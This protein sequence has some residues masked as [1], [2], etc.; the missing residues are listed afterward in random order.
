M[1]KVQKYWLQIIAGFALLSGVV[2]RILSFDWNGRLHGDVNLFA[3]TAREF[4]RNG[5]LFYPMKYEYSDLVTYQVMQTP[6]SQHPPLWPFAAGV[7]GRLFG[8]QDTYTIL[9]LLCE[10]VGIGLLGVVIVYGWRSKQFVPVLIAAAG[11]AL[12][13]LLIDFS[14]NGSSYILSAL[15]VLIVVFLLQQFN[16]QNLWHYVGAG[17]ICGIGFQVH[18]ALFLLPFAFILFWL[19][20]FKKLM[21]RGVFGAAGAGLVTLL[22]WMVWNWVHF[23]RPFYS[24]SSYYILRKL[25]IAHTGLFDNVI[26]TRVTGAFNRDVF[27][28]YMTL[29]RDNGDKFFE[30]YYA[31]TGP[32]ILGFAAIGF[33]Y[34]LWKDRRQLMTLFLPYLFYIL[35]IILW[36][37]YKYRFLV[38]AIPAAYLLAGIGIDILIKNHLSKTNLVLKS[39]GVVGLIGLFVWFIPA[40]SETPPTRYYQNDE[41]HLSQYA[42]MQEMVN[43]LNS[44]DTGIVMGFAKSLDGGIE[45]VYWHDMPFV[46]GRGLDPNEVQKLAEDFQVR[47]VWVDQDMLAAFE[48]AFPDAF[49]LRNNDLYAIFELPQDG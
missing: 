39:A 41:K 11:M 25:D 21:W 3:L 6:A 20:D 24:Y 38:P 49:L 29:V 16:Y 14:A 48:N 4:V 19:W 45:T 30:N 10:G 27:N 18:S 31:E 23:K 35:M 12:S 44:F 22:P 40:Y 1:E 26:T 2:L 28:L 15:I 42:Q 36:A 33:I 17:V 9:K 5:R 8:S 37:T 7:L 47:Y 46:F 13:P 32:I 34:L 43:E